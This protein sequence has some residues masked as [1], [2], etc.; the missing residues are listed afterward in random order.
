MNLRRTVL[1]TQAG[2]T[3]EAEQSLTLLSLRLGVEIQGSRYFAK[4]I[5]PTLGLSLLPTMALVPRSELEGSVNARG[6]PLE[7]TGGALIYPHSLMP[8]IWGPNGGAV[9]L[10][11]Q[12]VFGSVDE[13]RMDGLGVLGFFRMDL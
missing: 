5:S 11:A 10:V 3:H 6:L 13:S 8:Q 4:V 7:V 2:G 12:Y 9:G 1:Q